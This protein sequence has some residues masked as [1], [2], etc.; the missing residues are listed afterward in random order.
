MKSLLVII[1]L[2]M[3]I[4]TSAQEKKEYVF[5][6]QKFEVITENFQGCYGGNYQGDKIFHPQSGS[7]IEV[8]ERCINCPVK[9]VGIIFNNTKQGQRLEVHYEYVF[10]LGE[11]RIATFYFIEGKWVRI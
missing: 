4:A 10:F 6:N 5:G 7:S 8:Q 1:S 3:G 9:V 11:P 2:A